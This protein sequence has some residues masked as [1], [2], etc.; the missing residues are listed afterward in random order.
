MGSR[1]REQLGICGV[2]EGSGLETKCQEL[3]WW[4]EECRS[5]MAQKSEETARELS[6]EECKP[7]KKKGFLCKSKKA[8]E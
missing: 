4:A 5:T 7:K 6:V 2:G 8:L 1:V 3:V